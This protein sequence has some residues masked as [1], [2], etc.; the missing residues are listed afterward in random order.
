[1][2]SELMA[3]AD[4][5]TRAN[6]RNKAWVIQRLAYYTNF[7]DRPLS[8]T[9]IGNLAVLFGR[10]PLEYRRQVAYLLN[11]FRLAAHRAGSAQTGINTC[12]LDLVAVVIRPYVIRVIPQ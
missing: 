8:T 3:F 9:V 5:E 11:A 10:G 12:V 6:C 2:L 4:A 1:M 7:N